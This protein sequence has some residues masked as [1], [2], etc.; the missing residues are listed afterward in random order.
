MARETPTALKAEQSS[1]S[2]LTKERPGGAARVARR[3]PG[4]PVGAS[5]QRNN[6]EP[7][8]RPSFAEAL[9]VGRCE[10][11]G[12]SRSTAPRPACPG[13]QGRRAASASQPIRGQ[14]GWAQQGCGAVRSAG[15]EAIRAGP[16]SCPWPLRP[17]CS[18]ARSLKHSRKPRFL[19][20]PQTSQGYSG[21]QIPWVTGHL[22]YIGCP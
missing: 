6:T 13:R 19:S 11:R 21:E 10:M 9:G 2:P 12:L 14:A 7:G 1:D 18:P 20:G 8:G 3:G 16:S 15:F 4:V 5:W 17:P 22:T